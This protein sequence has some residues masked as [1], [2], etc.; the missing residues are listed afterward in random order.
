MCDGDGC[1]HLREK[2]VENFVR[3]SD[4]DADADADDSGTDS[5]SDVDVGDHYGGLSVEDIHHHHPHHYHHHHHR[6][7]SQRVLPVEVA[8]VVSPKFVLSYY[9]VGCS[10]QEEYKA[11]VF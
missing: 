8:F 3:C 5:D 6:D 1:Y 2:E 7:A 4:A 9:Q 10:W 11:L